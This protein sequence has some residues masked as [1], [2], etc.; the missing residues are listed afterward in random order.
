MICDGY[1]VEDM[2]RRQELAIAVHG[3]T[4]YGVIP[5]PSDDDELDYGPISTW[6]HTLGLHLSQA[7]ELIVVEVEAQSGHRALSAVAERLVAGQRFE[8]VCAELGFGWGLVHPD[9]V[10]STL[11]VRWADLFG[12]DPAE[13]EWRQLFFP[14]EAYCCDEHADESRVPL[15]LPARFTG[16]LTP[17]RAA[18]R[19]QARRNRKGPNR[20]R[21][22]G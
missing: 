2:N 20:P 17:N 6:F 8:D 21:G 5:R 15:D 14:D 1:S 22:W 11:C 18:R 12:R 4:N 10:R 13:V 7:P 3:F 16:A 9:H 19:A